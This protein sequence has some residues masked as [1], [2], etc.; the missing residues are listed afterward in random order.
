MDIFGNLT[1]WIGIATIVVV[2]HVAKQVGVPAEQYARY[3]WQGRTIEYR[4]AQIRASLG[5]RE[6]TIQDG[7]EPVE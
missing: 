3:E 5:F 1:R 4:R 2:A 7:E 6:G